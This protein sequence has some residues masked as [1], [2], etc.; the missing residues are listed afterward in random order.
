MD[1]EGEKLLKLCSLPRKCIASK[2]RHIHKKSKG[3]DDNP[4]VLPLSTFLYVVHEQLF[5]GS[6]RSE[7]CVCFTIKFVF[8]VFIFYSLRSAPI[9]THDISNNR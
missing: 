9:S 2:Q 4:Y 3:L 5:L 7:E 1:P 8:P 6:E